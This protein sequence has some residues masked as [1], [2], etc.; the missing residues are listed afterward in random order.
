MEPAINTQ[1]TMSVKLA[2]VSGARKVVS[3]EGMGQ[4]GPDQVDVKGACFNA[5]LDAVEACEN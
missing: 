1:H 2:V 3:M 5:I 4:K